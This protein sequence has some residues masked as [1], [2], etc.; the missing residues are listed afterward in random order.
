MKDNWID[1]HMR[2]HSESLERL[3]REMESNAP[4]LDALIKEDSQR[5]NEIL[6]EGKQ[7]L[8]KMMNQPCFVEREAS[9]NRL[10]AEI[11][12]DSRLDELLSELNERTPILE[13]MLKELGHQDHNI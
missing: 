13:Q 1:E 4:L 11:K 7:E 10:C 2:E 12:A 6:E 9:L 3:M 5:L 8:D